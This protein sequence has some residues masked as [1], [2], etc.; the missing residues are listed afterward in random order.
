MNTFQEGNWKFQS[1]GQNFYKIYYNAAGTTYIAM[2]GSVVSTDFM[3]PFF[4]RWVRISFYQ[5]ASD[6]TASTDYINLTLIRTTS[7]SAPT[8]FQEYLYGDEEMRSARITEKF[9]E[10]FE[11]E[12][13]TYKLSLQAASTRRVTPQFIIQKLEG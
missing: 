1:I 12:G 7:T 5:T 9:G 3:I 2:T 10:G 8:R 11:Y 13:G 6:D 4:H